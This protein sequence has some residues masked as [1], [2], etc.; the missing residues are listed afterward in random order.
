MEHHSKHQQ[1]IGQKGNVKGFDYVYLNVTLVSMVLCTP[2]FEGAPFKGLH[3]LLSNKKPI[4]NF[5]SV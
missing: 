4:A 2:I 5:L 1:K 3:M